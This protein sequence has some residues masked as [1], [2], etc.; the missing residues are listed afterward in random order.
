MVLFFDVLVRYLYIEGFAASVIVIRVLVCDVIL[1]L[2][3]VLID[4]IIPT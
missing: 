3:K 2:N 4:N 1:G